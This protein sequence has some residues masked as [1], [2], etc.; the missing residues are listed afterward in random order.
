M[1]DVLTKTYSPDLSTVRPK[2]SFELAEAQF[3]A[4]KTTRMV[5]KNSRFDSEVEQKHT[6]QVLPIK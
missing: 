4:S 6:M 1:G 5:E 3:Q 2:G